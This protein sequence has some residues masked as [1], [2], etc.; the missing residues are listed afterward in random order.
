MEIPSVED[1]LWKRVNERGLV[2]TGLPLPVHAASS[3]KELC[4]CF[5]SPGFSSAI[6]KNN[7]FLR[8]LWCVTFTGVFVY[9]KGAKLFFFLTFFRETF[10]VNLI[11]FYLLEQDV[12]C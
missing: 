2:R 1:A 4:T 5:S 3:C 9:L 8:F 11:L 12:E 6:S 7:L 10:Y